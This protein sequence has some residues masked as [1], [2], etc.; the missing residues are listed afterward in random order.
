MSEF[1]AVRLTISGNGLFIDDVTP[2][3]HRLFYSELKKGGIF[4]STPISQKD[5]MEYINSPSSPQPL[6]EEENVLVYNIAPLLIRDAKEDVCILLAI[7]KE[8]L[9]EPVSFETTCTRETKSS[10]ITPVRLPDENEIKYIITSNQAL[11]KTIELPELETIAK[12]VAE[13]LGG[14]TITSVSFDYASKAVATKLERA[15]L[16]VEDSVTQLIFAQVLSKATLL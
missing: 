8:E 10:L 4:F 14:Q 16:L 11:Q 9:L 12:I 6:L 5:I 7:T 1:I 13:T 2:V 3:L 15:G